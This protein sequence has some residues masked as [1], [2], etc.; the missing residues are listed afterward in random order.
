MCIAIQNVAYDI[1]S[2]FIH[3]GKSC[4]YRWEKLLHDLSDMEAEAVTQ[5]SGRSCSLSG[6]NTSSSTGG[7]PKRRFRQKFHLG[8]KK[9]INCQT[10]GNASF[11]NIKKVAQSWD[12]KAKLSKRKIVFSFNF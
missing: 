11:Q 9:T 3:K 6:M 7:F 5:G 10:S 12:P 4:G 1:F 2:D 8:K